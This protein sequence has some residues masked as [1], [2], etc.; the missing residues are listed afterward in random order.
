MRCNSKIAGKLLAGLL[1][2]QGGTV[3]AAAENPYRSIVARNPFSLLPPDPPAKAEEP[4]P[5]TNVKLT[6]I[7]TML[8]SKRALLLVQETGPGAKPEKSVILREGQREGDIEVL[9]IDEKAG[10]VTL[11]NGGILTTLNFEKDGM[12]AA[13]LP[14]PLPVPPGNPLA[15]SVNAATPGGQPGQT[16][17]TTAIPQPRPIGGL[18]QI[19]TRAVRSPPNPNPG[20]SPPAP[21]GTSPYEPPGGLNPGGMSPPQEGQ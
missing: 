12:K 21:E 19:P 1:I 13:P 5:P 20:T 7:T 14:P 16:A 10:A 8:G 15:G 17:V 2:V 9:E 6:G 11:K 18:R 3:F 4:K